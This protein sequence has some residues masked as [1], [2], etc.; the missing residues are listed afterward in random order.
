MLTAT[1][2]TGDDTDSYDD[3]D[4][5]YDNNDDYD[6]Y[7]IVLLSTCLT[8]VKNTLIVKINFLKIQKVTVAI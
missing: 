5:S 7:N 6:D 4:D 2:T 3:D 8:L 1:S